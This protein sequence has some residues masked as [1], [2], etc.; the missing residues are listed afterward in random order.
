MGPRSDGATLLRKIALVS[1]V[2]IFLTG[3]F[4]K[5]VLDAYFVDRRPRE[6]KPAEGRIYPKYIISTGPYRATVY[7]TWKEKALSDLLIPF[8]FIMFGIG[9]GLNTRW[10]LFAPYKQS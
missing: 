7:L 10:K 1:C 4:S 6:P 5:I 3:F 9:Y 8:S 2:V